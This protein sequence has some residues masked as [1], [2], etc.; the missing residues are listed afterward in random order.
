MQQPINISL[1]ALTG[2]VLLFTVSSCGPS[3]KLQTAEAQVHELNVQNAELGQSINQLKTEVSTLT[4]KNKKLESDFSVQREQ[5]DRLEAKYKHANDIL[6]DQDAILKQIEDKLEKA[7]GDLEDRGLTVHYKKG[8]LY[9]SMEDQL[10]YRSGSSKMEQ[11]GVEALSMIS[12][13]MNDYPDVKV[14]VIGNTDD[15]LVK[16]GAD[17]W[18][19]STERANGVV[20][21]LRDVYKIDPARITS[22]GKGRFDPVADNSTAEGRAKNRRIEIIFQPDMDKVWDSLEY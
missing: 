1:T 3:K 11:K 8:L 21:T 19:L 16:K 14:I 5:C 6:R 17:N 15:Q 20:R 4:E 22:A 10:L 9:V 18:T 13:V 12:A 7:L 2:L